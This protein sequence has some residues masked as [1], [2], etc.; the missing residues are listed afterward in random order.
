MGLKKTICV[1]FYTNIQKLFL[2]FRLPHYHKSAETL[3]GRGFQCGNSVKNRLPHVT[4]GY[5]KN[6]AV[7][8]IYVHLCMMQPQLIIQ[9]FEDDDYL[10]TAKKIYE[11]FIVLQS[12]KVKGLILDGRIAFEKGALVAKEIKRL[13]EL[14]NVKFHGEKMV[15]RHKRPPDCIGGY[16]AH[17]TFRF[18]RVIEENGE[19]VYTFWRIQ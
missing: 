2:Q 3:T 15:R 7:L 6:L 13:D 14:D 12:C 5:H 19:P 16:L 10:D 11:K 17:K 1:L 18:K 8:Y 9:V 4:T